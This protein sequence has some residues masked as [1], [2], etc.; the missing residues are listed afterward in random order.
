MLSTSANKIINEISG[1]PLAKG[2][3]II[4]THRVAIVI[5]RQRSHVVQRDGY[6]PRYAPP[7]TSGHAK[8]PS[9]TRGL[10]YVLI[11]MCIGLEY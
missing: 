6:L 8:A 5:Y 4:E 2:D 7:A 9:I 11:T 10:C 3:R 1:K